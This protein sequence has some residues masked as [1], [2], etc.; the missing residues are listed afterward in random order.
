VRRKNVRRKNVRRKNVRRKNV[1]RENVRR[2]NVRRKKVR[3]KKVS[4][5]SGRGMFGVDAPDKNGYQFVVFLD[6]W[7]DFGIGDPPAASNGL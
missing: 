2:E 5:E 6:P 4:R 1:R 7:I 3:R